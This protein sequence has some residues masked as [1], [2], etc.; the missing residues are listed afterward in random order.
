MSSRQRQ[1]HH[2]P[3]A[4]SWHIHPHDLYICPAPGLLA[5]RHYRVRRAQVPGTFF[6]SVL[7]N[8]V[9]STEYWRIVDVADDLSWLL[10][11]YAGAAAAAGQSY[12]GSI[13]VTP[14]GKWP[15]PQYEE[16]LLAAFDRAGIKKWEFFGVNWNCN[17]EVSGRPGCMV[18]R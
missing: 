1:H 18:V 5:C 15:E 11:F 16:R 13:L 7:D 9:T 8:G 2:R 3:S 14:D 17:C 4:R 10:F 12:S 6:F